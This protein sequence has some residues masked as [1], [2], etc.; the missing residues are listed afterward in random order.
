MRPRILIAA[1]LL[2]G[3]VLG[4]ASLWQDDIGEWIY[5]RGV[6]R[7]MPVDVVAGLDDGLHVALCGTGSPMPDTSR[8][9]P[10]T[11][12]IAGKRMF[13]VDMGSGA[14]RNFN[15]MGIKSGKT[16]A[17]LLTHFHS[18]HIGGLGDFLIQRWANSGASTPLP[19]YGPPGT[20]SI[21]DATNSLMERDR[22]YRVKHHGNLMPKSG[23]GGTAV[24]FEP[25]ANG[26][27]K[28]IDD[29]D[30]TIT[31]FT[32]DHGGINPAVGYRFDY[33]GR[34]VVISGDTSQSTH[35][36]KVAADADILVH[37][38]LNPDMI[39]AMSAGF[40]AT[41]R[42][43]LATIFQQIK[44]IH[45]TSVEAAE[46]ASRAN[47]RMLILS[48]LIPPAPSSFL[49]R[50]FSRGTS[51]VFSGEIIVGHDGMLFSLVPGG[52]DIQLDKLL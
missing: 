28:L 4:T 6:K 1:F 36:E 9:G 32:V 46:S 21:V 5:A 7:Q 19:V 25:D 22:D 10:C 14:S 47:V 49:D 13:V 41:D 43:R 16:E 2:I 35:L 18:D 48:H 40:K 50:Y 27:A 44:A 38:T 29:G 37:E 23:F 8:M 45:T 34:S 52:K 42:D 3:I 51:D 26:I 20:K 30:L 39:D 12:V 24:T 11:A 31:A 15:P 17:V 33:K